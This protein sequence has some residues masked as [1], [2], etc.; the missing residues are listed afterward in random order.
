V[1]DPD[2]KRDLARSALGAETA[3]ARTK[4][5]WN[6]KVEE[7]ILLILRQLTPGLF[8][9]SSP[10]PL[11]CVSVSARCSSVSAG[12]LCISCHFC[13]K[14]TSLSLSP[15]LS[16][17]LLG[18]PI[19]YR[20]QIWMD[21]CMKSQHHLPACSLPSNRLRFQLSKKLA[22]TK[23]KKKKKKEKGKT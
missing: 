14:G 2:I 8:S 23:G 11:L 19:F 16:Q 15:S 21:H 10:G 7:Q 6:I 5:R 18:P 1:S 9:H 4:Q 13:I 20:M 17:S 12:G 3:V 22:S